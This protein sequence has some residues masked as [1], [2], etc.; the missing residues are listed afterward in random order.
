MLFGTKLDIARQT[1]TGAGLDYGS[2]LDFVSYIANGRGK[3]FIMSQLYCL[4]EV[5]LELQILPLH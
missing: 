5:R 4:H 1:K 3:L 2:Y